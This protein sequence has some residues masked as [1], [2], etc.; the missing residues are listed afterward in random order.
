MLG[1]SRFARRKQAAPALRVK[2]AEN[3]Q[4]LL[5]EVQ[6]PPAKRPMYHSKVRPLCVLAPAASCSPVCGAAPL[7]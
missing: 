6:A 5:Q 7:S 4:W 3:V 1:V 2:A